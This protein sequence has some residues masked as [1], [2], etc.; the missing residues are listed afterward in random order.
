MCTH[1]NVRCIIFTGVAG[2]LKEGQQIGDI[3][4]GAD[5]VNYEFD[6]TGHIYTHTYI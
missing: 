6:C 2:G 5:C 1:F 3:I 4:L